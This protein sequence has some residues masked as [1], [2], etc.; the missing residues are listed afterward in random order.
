MTV[1]PQEYAMYF[2]QFIKTEYLIAVEDLIDLIKDENLNK[3]ILRIA[4]V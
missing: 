1:T 3:F 4:L 2:E